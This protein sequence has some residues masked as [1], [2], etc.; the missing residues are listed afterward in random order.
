MRWGYCRPVLHSSPTIG[1]L[2]DCGLLVSVH[3]N[4]PSC[5][6]NV[7]LSRIAPLEYHQKIHA[8]KAVGSVANPCR[9]STTRNA[10]N[11]ALFARTIINK[12]RVAS[13][14]THRADNCALHH[15]N[16]P[17]PNW[18]ITPILGTDLVLKFSSAQATTG[19]GAA[20]P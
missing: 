6:W 1:L 3:R 16:Y 19:L 10:Y 8:N 12:R 2:S 7:L 15:Q 18:Q 4:L 9:T 5:R 14:A 17:T 20:V 11:W 13:A